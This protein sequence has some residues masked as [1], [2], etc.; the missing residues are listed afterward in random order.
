MTFIPKPPFP[1]VPNLPGVP[2]VR[3]AAGAVAA[4]LPV[5]GTAAAIGALWR[6]LFSKPVWGVYKQEPQTETQEGIETVTVVGDQ[7]PVV[8]AD[9]VLDFGYQNENDIPAYPVQDGSY[10]SYN[11]VNLPPEASVRLSKG[12]SEN[13][14][15]E[16]LD[17]IH[18]LFSTLQLYKIVTPERTY[19]NVR[20]LRFELTRKERKGAYFITDADIYFRE[21]RN[22]TAQ[23]TTTSVTTQNARNSSALPVNNRGTVNGQAVTTAPS[24][25]GVVTK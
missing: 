16:F 10:A 14:R 4:V 5:L 22:V 8:S 15:R 18:G 2:Q 1:N 25:D 9:S 24:L 20:P 6:A 21:I 12:G 3:R 13:D 17:Q 19:N 7:S 11:E 23:Y